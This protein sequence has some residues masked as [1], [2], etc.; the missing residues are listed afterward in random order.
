MASA[1]GQGFVW[2]AGHNRPEKAL[3]VDVFRYADEDEVS[4]KTPRIPIPG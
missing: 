3:F 2:T 4:V 1:P